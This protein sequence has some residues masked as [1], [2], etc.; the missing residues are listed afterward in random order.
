MSQTPQERSDV[1]SKA[2]E[3]NCTPYNTH[4]IFNQKFQERGKLEVIDIWVIVQIMYI[5]T[6][7]TL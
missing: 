6:K 7:I 1:G 3:V 2:F 5:Y 4:V